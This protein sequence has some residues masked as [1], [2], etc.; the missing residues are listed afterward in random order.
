MTV[1]TIRS[2]A[3]HSPIA[4]AG[5]GAS[6]A[7]RIWTPDGRPL[8]AALADAQAVAVGV[9]AD[10]IIVGFPHACVYGSTC[11]DI[12]M[13]NGAGNVLPP[14]VM[15]SAELVKI[16]EDEEI[17]FA[18]QAGFA[19]VALLGFSSAQLKNAADAGPT[20]ALA[21]L[22]RKATPAVVFTHS[23]LD[24]HPSHLAGLA[25]LLGA[26]ELMPRH[27]QPKQLLGGEV[28]QSLSAL[29]AGLVHSKPIANIEHLTKL[30]KVYESQNSA[31]RYDVGLPGRWRANATFANP[32]QSCRADGVALYVDLTPLLGQPPTAL[33]DF[34]DNIY[35]Q[36][37]RAQIDELR[38]VVLGRAS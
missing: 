12:V 23:P 27:H 37:R 16:R 14:G 32:H 5:A 6:T 36:A 29:P 10:D 11:V 2:S 19:A 17:E 21:D 35:E 31:Q 1:D 18:R 13:T 26:Y 9:H 3:M 28:W 25:R 33:F 20:E 24:G 30:V 38:Q 8:S 7:E 15:S 22:L 34:V 4:D